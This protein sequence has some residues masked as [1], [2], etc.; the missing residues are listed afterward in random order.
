[1]IN[2]YFTSSPQCLVS[3][4]Y[5]NNDTK[6]TLLS[7]VILIMSLLILPVH[8]NSVVNFE[9]FSAKVLFPFEELHCLKIIWT[10]LIY[11]EC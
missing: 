2:V 9:Y 5:H 11:C 7:L 8:I 3:G 6:I 10:W 4:S 1:M